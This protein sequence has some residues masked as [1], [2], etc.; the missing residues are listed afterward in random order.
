MYAMYSYYASNQHE[1]H[2]VAGKRL[3]CDQADCSSFL[4]LGPP[5]LRD[6]DICN[7]FGEKLKHYKIQPYLFLKSKAAHE[8]SQRAKAN[9]A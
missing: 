5:Q 3:C 1:K 7:Q 2:F 8:D 6:W 4:I 9:T